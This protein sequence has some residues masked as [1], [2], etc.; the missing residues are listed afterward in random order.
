MNVIRLPEIK[1]AELSTYIMG[2][3]PSVTRPTSAFC[4]F[5]HSNHILY[6]MKM[7]G[8]TAVLTFKSHL[9]LLLARNFYLAITNSYLPRDFECIQVRNVIAYAVML[10][11]HIQEFCQV[12]PHPL[13]RS[14]CGPG[15]KANIMLPMA[16]SKL[17]LL[18]RHNQQI[19]QWSPALFLVREGGV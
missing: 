1:T 9:W 13:L 6:P 19:T 10:T 11:E 17:I 16:S 3:L 5:A 2:I 4:V 7:F 15:Y 18:T 14:A 12:S 8:K